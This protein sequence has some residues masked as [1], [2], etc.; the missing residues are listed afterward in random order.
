MTRRTRDQW[1][2]LIAEQQTSG[3]K[4]STFCRERQINPAYF[5]LRKKQLSFDDKPAFIQAK[6]DG[7]LPANPVLHYN[8]TDLTLNNASPAW[9]A[10]LLRELHV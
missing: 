10:Q 6:V 8:G 2:Q 3:L 5:S 1:R 7:A 9:V 4:A